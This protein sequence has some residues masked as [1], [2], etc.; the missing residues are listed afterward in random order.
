M[1][2]G[3]KLEIHTKVIRKCDT[4]ELSFSGVAPLLASAF[5]DE[6]NGLCVSTV[7]VIRLS[8]RRNTIECKESRIGK[9]PIEV[10][11]IVKVSLFRWLIYMFNIV[12]QDGFWSSFMSPYEMKYVDVKFGG[13]A[14]AEAGHLQ[15]A[16]AAQS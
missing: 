11:S 9:Q 12:S 13:K 15:K 14:E 6:R 4:F 5:L 2:Q 8:F 7:P 3:L 1:I 16:A 10:L